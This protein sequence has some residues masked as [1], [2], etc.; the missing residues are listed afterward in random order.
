MPLICD[1]VFQANILFKQGA[2]Y[3]LLVV[4]SISKNI[5][6]KYRRTQRVTGS[7]IESVPI[8]NVRTNRNR[9]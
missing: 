9:F 4:L 5:D 3:V 2:N 1:A 6:H 8:T 7:A